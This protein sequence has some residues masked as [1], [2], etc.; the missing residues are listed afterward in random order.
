M[1][2]RILIVDDEPDLC[3]VLVDHF[4]DDD[5]QTDV[6]PN[7][8][9]ALTKLAEFKPDVI[10]SDINMPV[11]DGMEL[12]EEIYKRQDETPLIF[13]SAFRD[14][15]KMK[16]AWSLCAFDFLDK[17]FNRAAMLQLANNAVTYG[18]DYVRSARKRFLKI[19]GQPD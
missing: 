8:R 11:M 10:L 1:K 6:A 16:K 3:E 18:R 5:W 9:V 19:K 13:I 15:E 14:L 7:G 12:L 4:Q 2:K 17:P